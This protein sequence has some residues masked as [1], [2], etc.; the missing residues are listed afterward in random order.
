[1]VGWRCIRAAQW[2][3]WDG[4]GSIVNRTDL[5]TLHGNFIS[6]PDD[7]DHPKQA[8]EIQAS[9]CLVVWLVGC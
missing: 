6:W 9:E 7:E 3:T 5:G 2:A 4:S 1:M 8:V